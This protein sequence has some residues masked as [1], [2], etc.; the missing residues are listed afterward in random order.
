M[1]ARCPRLLLVVL[2][3]AGFPMTVT[4]QTTDPPAGA[5]PP[6]DET[7]DVFGFTLAQ[8]ERLKISGVF[9]A[10]WSH[11]GAQAQLGFEKQG[12]VAQ[13]TMSLSG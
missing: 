12:R 11:D 3:L 2:C 1:I 6:E 8:N 13:A 4:A 10:G 9:I 5:Q 7:A